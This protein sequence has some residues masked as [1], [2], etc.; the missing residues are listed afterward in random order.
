MSLES[1][2]SKYKTEYN[3]LKIDKF[4]NN[5]FKDHERLKIVEKRLDELREKEKK[6]MINYG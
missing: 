4:C 6:E 5:N 1:E 3:R 2:I